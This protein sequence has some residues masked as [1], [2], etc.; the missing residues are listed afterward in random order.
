MGSSYISV[1][2]TLLVLK[3]S[4]STALPVVSASSNTTKLV[5]QLVHRDAISISRPF[6]N[7]NLVISDLTDHAFN[8]SSSRDEIRG[9]LF[10]DQEG[11][12]FLVNISIGEPQI[13]QLLAMDTGSSLTWV[14]PPLC[15]GCTPTS[16]PIY[17]PETSSTSKTVSC[18]S[19]AKCL[20]HTEFSNCGHESQ[21]LYSVRYLD[22]SI[23]TGIIALD[24]FTFVTS[25]GGE[26]VIPDLVFGYCQESSGNLNR[27]GGILGLQVFNN[28]SLVSRL[29]NKFS[30]CL[31]NISN[32]YYAYNRLTLGEGAVIEGYST[33]IKT[34]QGHYVVSLKGISVGGKQLKINQ[35]EFDFNVVVDSGSTLTYLTRS[36]YEELVQEVR[37]LLDGRLKRVAGDGYA[38]RRACYWGDLGRDLKGRFPIVTLSLAEGA[39]IYLDVESVFRR[40]GDNAFCMAVDVSES[41]INIIG[42]IAQQYYNVGFDLN[43]MRVSFRSIE[44]ELLED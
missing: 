1:S 28:Y 21:C 16:S 35:Q 29:G 24:K 13:P 39:E 33:P 32:P 19:N 3:V 44:C 4:F 42:V 17:D 2:L 38:D 36:A 5:L 7:T 10:P 6:K 27:L 11:S 20:N 15:K 26:W 25:T 22:D 43:A 23:S 9:P 37:G 31:G 8:T 18:D 14:Q 30:Y 34:W 40:A 41:G 12:I